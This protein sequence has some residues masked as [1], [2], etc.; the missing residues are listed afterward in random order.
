MV[1]VISPNDLEVKELE[2]KIAPFYFS[3]VLTSSL[4]SGI[5]AYTIG[6]N[7]WHWGTTEYN[8]GNYLGYDYD[9]IGTIGG[10]SSYSGGGSLWDSTFAR[11]DNYTY[12]DNSWHWGTT[13][14]N[15]GNYLGYNYDPM[16]IINSNYSNN[17][18]DYWSF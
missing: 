9:P 2:E 4:F 12:G 5:D 11:I 14:Y 18:F 6:D 17:Y 7:S 10:T 3:S 8:M 16:S 15:M 13:A 1:K